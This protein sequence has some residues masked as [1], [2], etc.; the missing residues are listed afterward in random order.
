MWTRFAFL[1]RHLSRI[2]AKLYIMLVSSCR[3]RSFCPLVI[4]YAKSVQTELTD[5]M[6]GIDFV[7]SYQFDIDNHVAGEKGRV[8]LALKCEVRALLSFMRWCEKNAHAHPN[9]SVQF[10]QLY[11][12]FC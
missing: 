3:E 9:K 10:E 11:D 5:S 12:F 2:L 1:E 8:H 4:E 6:D 7:T